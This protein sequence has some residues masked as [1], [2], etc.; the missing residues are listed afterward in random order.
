MSPVS[1]L[2]GLVATLL[3]LL[4]VIEMLRRRRLRE[5]HAVLWIVAG[6]FALIVGIFPVTLSWAAAL[7]GI[8]VPTNLIFFVTIAIL[9]F[10]CLQHSSELTQL[11]SKT[12]TLAERQALLELR[13]RAVESEPPR[14]AASTGTSPGDAVE[15]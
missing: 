14:G 2:L 4:G 10:V 1:Y 9:F 12:R 7:L 13:M 15:R 3:A 11:E 5:R 8:S 6:V